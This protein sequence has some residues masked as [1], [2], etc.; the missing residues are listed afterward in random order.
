M[1]AAENRQISIDD[2]LPLWMG[3]IGASVGLNIPIPT[4]QLGDAHSGPI[5]S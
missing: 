2:Y 3:I 1:K 4:H 5:H